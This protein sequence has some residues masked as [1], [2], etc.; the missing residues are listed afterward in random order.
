MR[1]KQWEELNRTTM[2]ILGGEDGSFEEEDD[3]FGMDL[4]EKDRSVVATKRPVFQIN[5]VTNNLVW[6]P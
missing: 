1:M 2:N 5:E 3:D 4:L 6:S